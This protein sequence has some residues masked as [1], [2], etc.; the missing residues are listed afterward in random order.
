[1][2]WKLLGNWLISHRFFVVLLSRQRLR[3]VTC[4]SVD[5]SYII[6]VSSRDAWLTSC[7]DKA[8]EEEEEELNVNTHTHI[9][10]IIHQNCCIFFV[11]KTI[12][13]E[14]QLLKTSIFHWELPRLTENQLS[15]FVFRYV[16]WRS[17][18]KIVQIVCLVL[19]IWLLFAAAHP[20]VVNSRT[21]GIYWIIHFY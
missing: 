6:I 18:V 13:N 17:R 10:Q 21:E 9:G 4:K 1:M 3:L 7:I 19:D 16:V 12:A 20:K 15:E 14:S 2:T 5:Q 8:I 11:G